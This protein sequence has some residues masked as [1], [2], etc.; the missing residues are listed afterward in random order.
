MEIPVVIN[1]L[2]HPV[3]RNLLPNRLRPKAGEHPRLALQNLHDLRARAQGSFKAVA[4]KVQTVRT[5]MICVDVP[6]TLLD[7]L[8]LLS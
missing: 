4:W 8:H 6:P 2:V 3:K 7:P 1:I 5:F